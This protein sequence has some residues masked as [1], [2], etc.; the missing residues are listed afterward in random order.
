MAGQPE[1]QIE[2]RGLPTS[3]ADWPVYLLSLE[4]PL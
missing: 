4:F 2:L 1:W 3:P